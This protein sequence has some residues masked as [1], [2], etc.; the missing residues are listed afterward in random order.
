MALVAFTGTTSITTIRANFDDATAALTT[1]TI[2]GQKDQI[3][4]LYVAALAVATVL[5]ARTVAWTQTDDAEVR[6]F[7]CRVTDGA[8]AATV[9]A[10]LT[11]DTGDAVFLIDNTVSIAVVA[12][13]GTVDSRTASAT[14]YR[15]TTGTRFRLKK[16][17][18]YR[19]TLVTAAATVDIA[20]CC[21]QLR[22]I[23]RIA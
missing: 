6:M 10:T 14:D 7:F 17:V 3:R 5:S 23:R 9:T 15:T 22:S 12:I 2:A 16:G 4:D 18:R 20:E 13:N 19:L 11:Q 21:L 8:A 1:N